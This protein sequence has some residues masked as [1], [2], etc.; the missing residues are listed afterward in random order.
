MTSTPYKPV[1][2]DLID[3][4]EH[5]ASDRIHV[6]IVYLDHT[7]TRVELRGHIAEVFTKDHQEFL[8]MDD[9]REVRLDQILEI[10]TE[11]PHYI[12]KLYT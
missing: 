10:H 8:R 7:Q 11:K 2:T 1:D 4:L 9:K 5:F 12:R 6:R 3:D